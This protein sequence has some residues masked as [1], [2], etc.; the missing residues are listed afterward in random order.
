M[1]AKVTRLENLFGKLCET[2]TKSAEATA[3]KK[4]TEF[5]KKKAKVAALQL[6]GTQAV[7]DEEE[8]EDEPDA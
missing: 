5:P 7:D 2:L 6:K 3:P 1:S 4:S 8:A